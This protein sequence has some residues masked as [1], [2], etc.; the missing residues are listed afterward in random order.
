M[1]AKRAE[2]FDPSETAAAA[3]AIT[4][5]AAIT[6]YSMAVTPLRSIF[7]RSRRA[8]MYANN[9]APFVTGVPAAAG[10][11]CVTVCSLTN[12]L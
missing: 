9:P 5:P 2:T 11:L 7:T 6:P 4:M 1:L 3:T 10:F 8:K 12:P